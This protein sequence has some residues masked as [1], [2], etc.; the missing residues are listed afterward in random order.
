[1]GDQVAWS[2]KGLVHSAERIVVVGDFAAARWQ[3]FRS[4]IVAPCR[5]W[6]RDGV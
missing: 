4:M 1:M 6:F 5:R 3:D 2:L